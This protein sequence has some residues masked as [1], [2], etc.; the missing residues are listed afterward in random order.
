MEKETDIFEEAVA[1]ALAA[2]RGMKRKYKDLP[3]II[4]PFESVSIVSTM[5]TDIEVLAATVLHDA[6]EDAN[7]TLE[8]IENK[9]GKKVARLVSYSSEDKRKELPANSTW[10]IRKQETLNLLHEITDIEVKMICLADKISNLRSCVEMKKTLGNDMWKVFN[11]HDSKM[12][13]WYHE[14][15]AD[16]LKEL[17]DTDAYQEYISLIK[18]IFY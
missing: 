16:S 12:H 15:V 13:K 7:V 10:V 1:F 2:H 11:Q 14:G 6:V 3:F 8:D 18:K 17:Q 9:F 4:H 5:T